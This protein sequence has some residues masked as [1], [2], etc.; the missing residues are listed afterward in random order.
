MKGLQKEVRWFLEAD[1]N[2]YSH[3]NLI[4]TFC[5]INNVP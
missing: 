5:P 2:P 1:D 3:E 4:I